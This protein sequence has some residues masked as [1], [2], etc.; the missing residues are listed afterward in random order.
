MSSTTNLTLSHQGLNPRLCGKWRSNHLSYGTTYVNYYHYKNLALGLICGQL[1]TVSHSDSLRSILIL[2]YNFLLDLVSCLYEIWHCHDDETLNCGHPE[3]WQCTVW[4]WDIIFQG[5][6]A[7]IFNAEDY[8][9]IWCRN[10]I[11]SAAYFQ[12]GCLTKLPYAF[13][14]SLILGTCIKAA[15]LN[16]TVTT[17][18]KIRSSFL[19]QLLTP[20]L[21]SSCSCNESSG[22][23]TLAVECHSLLMNSWHGR[24]LCQSS[25]WNT[26]PTSLLTSSTS[27]YTHK[28]LGKRKKGV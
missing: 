9:T 16:K 24:G 26:Q 3:L 25:L 22:H 10:P 11:M 20:H 2:S 19:N 15:I 12:E 17:S 4:Q 27:R 13:L 6:M 1:F 21:S 14:I 28:I 8:Q 7:S 23:H 5:N 18:I